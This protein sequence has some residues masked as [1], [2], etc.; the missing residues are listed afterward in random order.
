MKHVSVIYFF[1]LLLMLCFAVFR[2]KKQSLSKTSCSMASKKRRKEKMCAFRCPL[3][4]IPFIDLQC[5]ALHFMRQAALLN[6]NRSFAGEAAH[7]F[8]NNLSAC[9]GLAPLIHESVQN[10]NNNKGGGGGTCGQQPNTLVMPHSRAT[11]PINNN[12]NNNNV[13]AL[14]CL[15]FTAQKMNVSL[16]LQMEAVSVS[17]QALALK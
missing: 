2:W 14:R 7:A 15:N 16:L 4:G 12:N 8:S 3:Q 11:L 13:I 5:R 9:F 17:L 6:N 10:N 1:L